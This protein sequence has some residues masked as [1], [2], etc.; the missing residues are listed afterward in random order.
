MENDESLLTFLTPVK[1]LEDLKEKKDCTED[2]VELIMKTPHSLIKKLQT[3][4]VKLNNYDMEKIIELTQSKKRLQRYTS[5]F[6]IFSRIKVLIKD[7]NDIKSVYEAIER[8]YEEVFLVRYRDVYPLIRAMCIQ[9]I[10]EWIIEMKVLRKAEYLKFV[11]SALNDKS[12]LVR[13]R[14]IKAFASLLKIKE[15][16]DLND[17][18][19]KYK[20]RII[21]ISK[22]D[23]N[24]I[25]RSECTKTAILIFLKNDSIFDKTEILKIVALEN[26]QS[27]EIYR[28][29]A[30]KIL[31]DTIWDLE[32]IHNHL[33]TPEIFKYLVEKDE[34]YITL[35]NNITEFIKTQ[36]FCCNKDTICFFDIMKDIKAEEDRPLNIPVDILI[37]L[38]NVVKSNYKNIVGF[39]RFIVNVRS[40]RY[41]PGQT[42][43]LIDLLKI[44]VLGTEENIQTIEAFVIFLK[45]LEEH[46]SIQVISI[47]D[48]IK[49]RYPLIVIKSFDISNESIFLCCQPI[50]KCYAALWKVIQE[51]YDWIKNIDFNEIGESKD[52]ENYFELL[53]FLEFFHSKSQGSNNYDSKIDC[54]SAMSIIYEKLYTFLLCNFKFDSADCC[55]YLFKL[56]NIGVFTQFSFVLFKLAKLDDLNYFIENCKD[57]NWLIKGYFEALVDG[58]KEIEKKLIKIVK[59]VLSKVQKH[60]KKGEILKTL[61]EGI[62][63]VVGM[64]QLLDTILI[65]F[66]PLLGMNEAIVLENL[67]AKSKFKTLCLKKCKVVRPVKSEENIT[68]I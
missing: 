63:S 37:N 14:A 39:L 44:S 6:L 10:S 62:K 42:F 58:N 38:I 64:S 18:Y 29:V 7:K 1:V 35:L 3:V 49:N 23:V 19:L 2:I 27:P 41:F 46:F 53:D 11:G 9:F 51:D 24:L 61:F 52:I 21:E 25:L 67:S 15:I 40:F 16:N 17:F 48:Q 34:D 12:N 66:I 22:F 20:S 26:I 50:L 13:R 31:P 36:S 59:N 60:N 54:F 33:E 30:K 55:P 32:E 56:L 28:K 65:Y 47:I 68:F 57:A 8:L 43:E 4:F 45:R 5:T